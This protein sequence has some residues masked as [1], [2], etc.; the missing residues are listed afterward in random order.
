MILVN[1]EYKDHIHI[2]DRGFQYGDGLFETIEV[3]NG[4]PVFLQ[5]HLAR[6]RSGCL[7]MKI[8][9][10]DDDLILSEIR[11]LCLGLD[12]AV[13]KIIITRGEGGRGYRPPQSV[14]PNRVLS[15]HPSPDYP[16][17]YAIQ[18]ICARFCETK[19]GLNPTL[20]G[21][22]HLNRLEQVLARAEWENSSIQEGLLNDMD[23]N[24]I[25]GTMS[26][27][28]YVKANALYTPLLKNC[29]VEGIIKSIVKQLCLKNG[30][31]CSENEFGR[32]EL[33]VADE[34]FV[35]NSIIGIWPINRLDDVSF[36][37]GELTKRI[38]HWFGRFKAKDLAN[39]F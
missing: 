28:F 21:I 36:P 24:I 14:Q 1:G 26:N 3:A 16:V 2:A 18:G 12:S 19:L 13:L 11:Q 15:L 23:G 17:S 5:Q 6:L 9:P 31:K 8:P 39:V 33:L 35:C 20:A 37:V 4:K 29:G 25:E 7:Q 32:E 22:K 34:A 27:L 38:Q 10:P 30:L